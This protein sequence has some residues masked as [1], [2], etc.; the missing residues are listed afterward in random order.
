MAGRRMRH[1]H[2]NRHSQKLGGNSCCLYYAQD[3]R[4]YVVASAPEV[5]I[6]KSLGIVENAVIQKKLTYRMGGPVLLK[7][8]SSEIAIG[9]DFAEK[10]EVRG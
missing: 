3:G 6:L 8:D 1:R 2:R 9:K 10:I 4:Q 7:V 5:G